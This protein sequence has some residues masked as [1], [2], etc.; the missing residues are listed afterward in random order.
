ML[1][2]KLLQAVV[3]IMPA[4]AVLMTQAALVQAASEECRTKPDLSAPVGSG[5]W[6]YRVDRINQ[7]RCWFLSSED[8]RTRHFSSLRH[9]ESS[10]RNTD[11]EIEEQ[12]RLD[13]RTVNGLTPIQDPAVPPD[14]AMDGEVAALELHA[15]TAESLVPHKVTTISFVRPRV[16][17][18]SLERG[19]NFDLIFLG[20]ALATALLVAGAVFQIIDRFNRSPRTAS[21]GPAP[22]IKAMRSQNNGLLSEGTDLKKLRERLRRSNIP[23]PRLGKAL[24]RDRQLH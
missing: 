23:A 11:L 2:P 22:L 24:L 1:R 13:G 19:T 15:E 20:G 6:H 16:E 14:E 18:Q 21:P 9:R 8:S 10:N 12:S 17:E 7:R 3:L 5:H 4:A